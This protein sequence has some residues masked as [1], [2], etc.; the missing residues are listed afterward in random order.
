MSPESH[1]TLS[2]HLLRYGLRG[3][4]AGSDEAI[5]P[6]A[7]FEP[8]VGA[9]DSSSHEKCCLSRIAP[10]GRSPVKPMLQIILHRAIR[11]Q[12][13]R[14]KGFI[15]TP[16]SCSTTARSV[17]A[18]SESHS[19]VTLACAICSVLKSSTTGAKDFATVEEWAGNGRSILENSLIDLVCSVRGTRHCATGAAGLP[20]TSV[21][22]GTDCVTTLPAVTTAPRPIT[23]LGKIMT[24]G[25]MN[26]SLSI[27][28]PRNSRN[29]R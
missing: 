5:G 12:I 11:I 17:T 24:P 14:S 4:G 27:L 21:R 29:V 1:R 20:C 26:A 7:R 28:T 3:L 9:H 22:G 19:V 10:L 18:A 23:T 15:S 25:P 13:P 16:N 2:K 8:G 6:Q